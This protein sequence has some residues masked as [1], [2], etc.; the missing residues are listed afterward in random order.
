[1][2]DKQTELEVLI[3]HQQRLLD[4]LN[5][6]VTDQQH[7]IDQLTR[8]HLRMKRTIDR[9]V[10]FYEGADTSVDERPPHY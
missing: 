6:V 9:L 7:Q 3:A 8:D 2:S 10:Q 4:E 5:A 1:M